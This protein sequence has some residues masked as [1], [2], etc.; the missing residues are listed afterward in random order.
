M[1]IDFAG[2]R[3][4]IGAFDSDKTS[5]SVIAC[6]CILSAALP[7]EPIYYNGLLLVEQLEQFLF[8]PDMLEWYRVAG[9][10]DTHTHAEVLA[11][12]DRAIERQS[13]I[14]DM[15]AKVVAVVETEGVEQ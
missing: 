7:D 15:Q 8:Y 6:I 9:Y 10:N 12:F 11:V 5:E 14:E 13:M 3:C 4:A 2:R 1:S